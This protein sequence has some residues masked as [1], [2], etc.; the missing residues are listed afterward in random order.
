MDDSG[1]KVPPLH[2]KKV[3]VMNLHEVLG[4]PVR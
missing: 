1:A 4:G 2:S 3:P